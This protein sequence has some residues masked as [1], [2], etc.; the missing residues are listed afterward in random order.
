[1]LFF[2]G[3]LLIEPG[4]TFVRARSLVYVVEAQVEA[5]REK[6]RILEGIWGGGS[7]A[8]GGQGG[9]DEP[10]GFGDGDG[11]GG[12]A[13]RRRSRQA[14]SQR[15]LHVGDLGA[16]GDEDEHEEDEE[17]V[18]PWEDDQEE[19]GEEDKDQIPAKGDVA[20]GDDDA[21]A[22]GSPAEKRVET[23]EACS[24]RTGPEGEKNGAEQEEES[25]KEREDG[26]DAWLISYNARLRKEL[27]RLR[28]R[29]R[30]AEER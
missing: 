14:T 22:S 30:E 11:D 7:G 13:M 9:R 10:E 21:G 5:M 29:A 8:R 25:R 6:I 23:M 20:G 28:V 4:A 2:A 15:S 26:L 24:E 17:D 18:I 16:Q 12:D 1:M 27:E 19:E 3:W